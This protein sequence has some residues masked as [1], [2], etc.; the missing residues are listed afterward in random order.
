MKLKVMKI[1]AMMA[2]RKLNCNEFSKLCGISRQALSTIFK[3][4]TCNCATAGKIAEALSVPVLEI[5]EEE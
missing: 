1:K 5:M 4:G 3:R 2:E